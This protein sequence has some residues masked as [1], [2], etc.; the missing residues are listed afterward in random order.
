MLPQEARAN[1]QPP[2]RMMQ[3]PVANSGGSHH[4]SA[5]GYGFGHICLYFCAGEK[6]RGAYR[7]TRLSECRFKR[8]NQPQ[9]G[10]AKVAHG[11]RS[12]ANV[13][14]VARGHQDDVQVFEL[15]RLTQ[16]SLF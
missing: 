16:G 13:E 11:A 9:P 12:C 7:G 14:R 4:E 6:F 15:R 8:R 10:E 2:E 3:I 1:F 5:I